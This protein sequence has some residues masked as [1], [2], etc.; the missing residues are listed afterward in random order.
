[1]KPRVLKR[2]RDYKAALAYVEHLME[3]R[4]PDEAE[5]KLWSLLVENYEEIH[6]PIDTPKVFQD[7]DSIAGSLGKNRAPVSIKKMSKGATTA[8]AR[9]GCKGLNVPD[10]AKP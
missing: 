5:L 6:F 1:M 7:V 2:D 3:Q 8:I 4:S 10:R 9:A